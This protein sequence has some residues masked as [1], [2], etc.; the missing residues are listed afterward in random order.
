MW[1]CWSGTHQSP[2]P[3]CVSSPPASC[4]SLANGRHKS[5]VQS[6]GRRK[7]ASCFTQSS[8][9]VCALAVGMQRPRQGWKAFRQRAAEGSQPGYTAR[10]NRKRTAAQ[11][12]KHN[13]KQA[14]K[15]ARAGR[16]PP[17]QQQRRVV[18]ESSSSS[19]DSDSSSDESSSSSSSSALAPASGTR[20]QQPLTQQ[21]YKDM[22]RLMSAGF[23]NDEIARM[24]Q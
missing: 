18:V 13:A 12:E 15:R 14:E 20:K 8:G 4:A 7:A 9:S 22:T 21:D 24:Y 16:A 19:S 23:N 3:V 10:G 1:T 6:L 5:G 17:K 11:R 2:D